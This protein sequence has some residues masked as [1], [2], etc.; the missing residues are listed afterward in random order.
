M[1]GQF[2]GWMF[3]CFGSRRVFFWFVFGE[4]YKSVFYFPV[5]FVEIYTVYII[6]TPK[7]SGNKVTAELQ[8]VQRY[9]VPFC[10]G[11]ETFSACW[12][13]LEGLQP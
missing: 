10:R 3:F 8:Q 13:F 7:K 4:R 12:Y 2:R 1:V 5:F 6:S 9:V 11:G